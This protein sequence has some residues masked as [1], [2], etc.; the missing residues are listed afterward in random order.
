MLDADILVVQE[1]ED[2]SQSTEAYQQWAGDYLWVGTSKNKGVGVFA[3]KGH[4]LEKLN[5]Q[6]EF[7]LSGLR[8]RSPAL[9][10][11][12]S[13][14]KLFLPVRVDQKYTLLAVW[15][16]G[17]DQQAFGYVGQLWKYLQIHH[18]ELNQLNTM[19]IGDLNSNACWD[20][21]DRWWSHSSVVEELEQI[22][23]YS[24]YHEQEKE[25]QGAESQ[26]TFY[27]HRKLQKPYHIDYAFFSE[28]LISKSQI[29]VGLH[30]DWLEVSDHMP[31]IVS[32]GE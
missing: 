9:S 14:L 24:L 11:H 26:P 7:S 30:E 22:G 13:D 6:G 19:V 25:A 16:K 28:D 21:E 29:E 12:T 4:S 1:C 17:S 31:L 23:L 15:T 8:S 10:W 5:W 32:L 27:L 18:Y 20:K 2:P 3:R